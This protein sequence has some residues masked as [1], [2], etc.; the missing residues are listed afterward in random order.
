MSV[1]PDRAEVLARLNSRGSFLKEFGIALGL[2]CALI[3]VWGLI[4]FQ[5][6]LQLWWT[7]ALFF[8]AIIGPFVGM[9]VAPW[10]PIAV[11]VAVV[12]IG[13]VARTGFDS[14]LRIA[15]YMVAIVGWFVA[16]TAAFSI[17]AGPR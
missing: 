15:L 9:F 16:G 4:Q 2:C 11:A 14:R 3:A 12:A 7:L 10:A 6:L 5:Q 1:D 17:Y 13:A 8:F